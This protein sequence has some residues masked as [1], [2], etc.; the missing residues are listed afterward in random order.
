MFLCPT[1][2]DLCGD[3]Q[4]QLRTQRQDTHRGA[5]TDSA[6][7]GRRRAGAA[8]GPVRPG[9]TRTP[10]AP[11]R[12][13]GSGVPA[14]PGPGPQGR[15]YFPKRLLGGRSPLGSRC[16]SRLVPAPPPLFTCRPHRRPTMHR[17]V[18]S[19]CAAS[20]SRHIQGRCH[21]V[22]IE[23]RRRGCGAGPARAWPRPRNVRG[24]A[25]E[26]VGESVRKRSH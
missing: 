10:Q 3:E 23:T 22:T 24:G 21:A 20:Q 5:D 13:R 26:G 16:R 25:A 18:A 1:H 15:G 2:C 8:P 6:L 4:R 11:L 9:P 17:G 7:W 12:R 19:S 14:G